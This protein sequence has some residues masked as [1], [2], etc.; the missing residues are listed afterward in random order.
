MDRENQE[1]TTERRLSP[2]ERHERIRKIKKKRRFR[3]AIALIAIIL[4]ACILLSPVLLFAV[5][6]IRDFAIEGQTSYSKEEIVAASGITAGKSIFFADLDEAKVNIEKK[7]PYADNVQLTRRLPGTLVVTLESTDKAYAVEKSEGIYAITNRDFK[8][9]EITGVMPKDVVPVI[10]AV[11]EVTELGN[12]LSFIKTEEE[13]DATLNLIQSISSAIADSGLNGINLISIRSRSNIYIIYQ[14]RMVLR[15]GDSSDI[16]KKVALAK[17]VI[18]REDTIV[19]NEQ[20]GI[21]NLT[22]PMKAYFKPAEIRDIP[23]IVEYRNF[24]VINEKDSVEEAYAIKCKNGSYAIVN[25]AFKVLSFA[26]EAPE[27]IIPIDGYVPHTAKTGEIL[28]WGDNA[29]SKD[30][31]NVIRKLYKSVSDSGIGANLIGFDSDNDLYVI[32]GERV[33]MRMGSMGDLENKLAKGKSILAEQAEDA[34]GIIDLNDLEAAE[35]VEKEYADIP[36]L[37]EYKPLEEET[38]DKE[39]ASDKESESENSE[40]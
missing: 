1:Y 31:M 37:N 9:L 12:P 5:F 4:V 10:G 40:G 28:S 33:V 39:D 22:V 2:E 18:Q 16:A 21:I 32:C 20:T 27:G 15:L 11:P 36:E 13:T 29:S 14:E 23:E 25:P 34:V 35:F 30:T 19:S 38:S 24:I 3:R 17:K 8:V 26:D 6:R 7:L